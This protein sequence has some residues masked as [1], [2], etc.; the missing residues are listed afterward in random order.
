MHNFPHLSERGND[1]A[2]NPARIDFEI[3]EEASQNLFDPVNNPDG[4]FPLNVAEN[5][6]SVPFIK[7]QLI[8]ITREKDIPQM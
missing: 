2:T 3:F 7:E 8:K 6:I 1:L 4:A 5:Y